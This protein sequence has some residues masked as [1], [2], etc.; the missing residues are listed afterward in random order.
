MNNC[1]KLILNSGK[2]LSY[3]KLFHALIYYIVC[4][5]A[6]IHIYWLS[7]MAIHF[8]GTA[9]VRPYERNSQTHVYK[10][11]NNSP[12]SIAPI[13]KTGTILR[14]VRAQ[15]TLV[16]FHG[17]FLPCIDPLVSVCKPEKSMGSVVKSLTCDFFI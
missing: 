15:T 5:Y 13:R 12:I 4:G 17:F 11:G 2:S 8:M 6:Y 3:I 16:R 10:E 9:G 7:Q 1:K 14:W